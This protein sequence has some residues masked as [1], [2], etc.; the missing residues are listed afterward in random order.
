[1]WA[2]QY[3]LEL[4]SAQRPPMYNL[5]FKEKERLPAGPE[6][7]RQKAVRARTLHPKGCRPW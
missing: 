3:D 2:K 7:C 5:C 6:P 4:N 1:M